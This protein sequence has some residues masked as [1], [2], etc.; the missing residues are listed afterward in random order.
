MFPD[1]VMVFV[2][3]IVLVY[4][5]KFIALQTFPPASVVQLGLVPSKT[6]ILPSDAVG[7][8]LNDQFVLVPQ[9]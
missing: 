6:V 2:I 9:F 7:T 4:A 3:V 8:K 5:E 1:T